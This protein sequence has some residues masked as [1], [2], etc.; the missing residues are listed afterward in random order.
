M[1][2]L[3]PAQGRIPPRSRC[4][5]MRGR[6]ILVGWHAAGLMNTGWK[7]KRR[8]EDRAI[9]AEHSGAWKA[10]FACLCLTVPCCKPHRAGSN[11]ARCALSGR[12][13]TNR[14]EP[15][16]RTR[17]KISQARRDHSPPGVSAGPARTVDISQGCPRGVDRDGVRKRRAPPPRHWRRPCFRIRG[18]SRYLRC[19]TPPRHY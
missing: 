17:C 16:P 1:P 15:Q 2:C 8:D 11:V 3:S 10:N 9:F 13:S 5:R 18:L 12:Q 19:E 14:G 6:P 7:R 4:A